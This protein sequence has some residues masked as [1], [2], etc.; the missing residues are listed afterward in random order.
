MRRGFKHAARARRLVRIGCCSFR[1]KE[2]KPPKPVVVG[3][4]P[5]GPASPIGYNA[6]DV[7]MKKKTKKT[8]KTS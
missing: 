6:I 4:K 2:R 7:Q 8:K 1:K 3:S 5:T